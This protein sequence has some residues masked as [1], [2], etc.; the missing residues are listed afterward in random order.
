MTPKTIIIIGLLL[1]P[2]LIAGCGVKEIRSKTKFGP[3]FR[4]KGSDSTDSVRWTVQQGFDF[5]LKKGW[6][7]GVTYRRRDTS[8]GSG[9]ND[10]GVWIDFSFPIWEAPKEKDKKKKKESKKTTEYI[11]E[12]E[13]RLAQLEAMYDAVLAK[14]KQNRDGDKTY[15]IVQH[16][17]AKPNDSS[18]NP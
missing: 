6:T 9:D 17:T 16:S 3:E 8:R 15:T 5:K 11:T 4:H 13:Q 10:N 14:H 18:L 1:I 12:L 2:W 7:T